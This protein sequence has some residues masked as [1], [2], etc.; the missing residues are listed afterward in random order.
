MITN[1]K[2]DNHKLLREQKYPTAFLQLILRLTVCSKGY[3]FV[4]ASMS[5][6]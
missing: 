3:K 1:L 5:L 4:N 6:C 2:H